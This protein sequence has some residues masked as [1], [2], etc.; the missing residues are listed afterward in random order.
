[1][2]CTFGSVA[3]IRARLERLTDRFA[4]ILI[5]LAG[6]TRASTALEYALT[7]AGIAM[8]AAGV[9]SVIGFEINETLET[10]RRTF[11]LEFYSVCTGR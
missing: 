5:R 9:T 2:P 6:N 8:S 11:C 10:V 7:L 4:F 3:N 1:M